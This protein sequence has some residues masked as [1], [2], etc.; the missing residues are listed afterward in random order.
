MNGAVTPVRSK[1]LGEGVTEV[2]ANERG[3]NIFVAEWDDKEVARSHGIEVVLPART[4]VS[5]GLWVSGG[6]RLVFLVLHQL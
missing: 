5:A 4:G 3:D 6:W 2:V 1:E